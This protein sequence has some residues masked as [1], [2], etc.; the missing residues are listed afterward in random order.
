[1]IMNVNSGAE[2]ALCAPAVGSGGETNFIYSYI[3]N[4]L[5]SYHAWC[6]R[7]LS[8]KIIYGPVVLSVL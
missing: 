5:Y 2:D 1:M 8:D 7:P 6:G 4:Y 3:Y